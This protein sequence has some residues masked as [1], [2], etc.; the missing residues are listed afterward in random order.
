MRCSR[1]P[2][3]NSIRVAEKTL[4][5]WSS[6]PTRAR[7]TLLRVIDYLGFV[8][9]ESRRFNEALSAVEAAGPEALAE[10]TVPSCDG[11]S[12]ADLTWHLAEVQYFWASI[13]EGNLTN[14]SDVV[15]LQRPPDRELVAR[16][17]EQ[18][19]RLAEVLAGRDPTEPCWSWH[20]QGNSIGWVLRR[21]A[22]ESLIHRADAELTAKSI[23][24]ERQ[25]PLNEELSA[26]G[27]DEML[28][29]MLDIGILPDR[30]RF[31][32]SE[33]TARLIVPGRSWDLTIGRVVGSSEDG[34]AIDLSAIDLSQPADDPG[35]EISATASALNLWLWRRDSLPESAV[36]GDRSIAD[37]LYEE[38]AIE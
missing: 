11:W 31:V 27:V 38:A 34:D 6:T 37:E 7:T 14:Y 32:P 8:R 21:Q 36:V 2:A 15:P 29:V 18:G 24:V 13:V 3:L 28:S 33:R 26:D 22:H 35:V 19:N 5:G 10:T 20:S 1:Q 25:T 30:L 12:A 17:S 9:S 4:A 16:Q 23:G